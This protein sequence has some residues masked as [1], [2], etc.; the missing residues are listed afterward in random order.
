M[1]SDLTA[2]DALGWDAVRKALNRRVVVGTIR[3][4]P[5][6]RNRVW[7]V[8]TD[9]RPVV[10]KQFLSKG[11]GTEFEM[12]I[13]ARQAALQVPYPLHAG[14]NYLVSEYIAGE[15]CE[16]LINHMFSSVAA[17]GIGNWLARFHQRLGEGKSAMIMSDA[18]LSNFLVSDGQVYAV[19]LEDCR[20]GNP[21]EDLGRAAA[22]ILGSEPFFTPIKFDLCMRMIRS[23]ERYSGIQTAESVRPFIADHLRQDANMRPLFRRTFIGAAKSIERGWPKLA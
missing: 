14:D 17:D 4:V 11:C 2:L 10:V 20:L 19:D 9:V 22:S 16:M 3:F 6:R 7:V 5:S 21:L 23:Y 8:E 18:V 12:M 15:G 13:R 1:M